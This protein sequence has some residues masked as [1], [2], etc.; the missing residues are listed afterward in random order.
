MKYYT[1][2][3][4]FNCGID[5]HARQMFVCV[6]DRQGNVIS[7]QSA[8]SSGTTSSGTALKYLICG[9]CADSVGIYGKTTG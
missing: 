5:L 6:T 3:T 9:L 7:H 2:T 4:K 1:S 8:T